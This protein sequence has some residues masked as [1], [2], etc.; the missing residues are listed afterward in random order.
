MLWMP[1]D[2]IGI[3]SASAFGRYEYN[4]TEN[5]AVADFEGDPVEGDSFY[6]VYPYSGEASLSGGVLS[7]EL[8]SVQEYTPLSFAP[9]SFPMVA[10]VFCSGLLPDG[11]QERKH[12]SGVQEPL[13]PPE[14][15][16]DGNGDRAFRGI[17]QQRPWSV[18]S[19]HGGHELRERTGTGDVR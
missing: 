14:A 12:I 8:P 10:R 17:P 4:G 3:T 18:R 19:G 15:Q 1:G 2:A 13:R 11:C 16:S 5:T 7:L 9:A 6:A